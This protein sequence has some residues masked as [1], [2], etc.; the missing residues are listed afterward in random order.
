VNPAPV[1]ESVADAT[2]GC[3]FVAVL[4]G[5][6]GVGKTNLVANLAVAS[7]GLSRRVLV[8]D[9][10]FG[11]ANVD[12]LLGLVTPF[13]VE[14][15]LL[16]RCRLEEALVEGPQGLRLLPAAAGRSDLAALHPDHVRRLMALLREAASDFDLALVDAGAGIGPS[17]VGLASSCDRALIVTTPEPTSLADAYAAL[18]I[19]VRASAGSPP[20]DLVVNEVRDELQA[21][22]THARLERLAHR[23][24]DAS[25]GF[26]GFL[27]SDPRL[28]DAVACQRA[29]VELFP[30]AP[31]SRRLVALAQSLLRESAR[32]GG[33][34]SSSQCILSEGSASCT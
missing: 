1:G 2:L 26:R 5:K 16:G 22:A 34:P 21:R 28:A 17:V 20:V 13:T 9:G 30:A 25:I 32:G 23:F 18:K 6:G 27:P 8:V 19:L 12:V 3:H 33:G 31:S 15:V 14:D 24:L 4:S 7:A 11:L 29:V 10:D